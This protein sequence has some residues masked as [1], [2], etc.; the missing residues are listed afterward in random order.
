MEKCKIRVAC[1]EPSDILY[2]GITNI[3]M[4]GGHHYFFS[5]VTDLGELGELLSSE[6]FQVAVVNPA[7][8]QNLMSEFSRIR[9]QHSAVSWLAVSYTF[10]DPSVLS[11][12]SGV[13]SLSDSRSEVLSK[14]EVLAKR[15][16]CSDSLREELSEREKDV[17]KLLVGGRSNKEISD[18]LNISIHTVVSHRKN[19]VRKTGIKSLSGLAIYAITS[20]IVPLDASLG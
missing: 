13:I 6:E 7:S 8:L 2:E 3:L 18:K 11:L 20:K 19:I 5:R 9:K 1:L 16:N 12:F 17:L 4:R 14:V 15:C 10:T